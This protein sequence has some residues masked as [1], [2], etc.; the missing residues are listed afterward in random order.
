MKQFICRPHTYIL[1]F[2]LS[3]SLPSYIYAYLGTS[4]RVFIDTS[5]DTVQLRGFG[6]GG[7]LVQEGYMWNTS[8]FYGS[9]SVIEQQIKDLVGD[10]ATSSFYQNYYS[11]YV[12]EADIVQLS[13]WG[14]NSLRV[15]FHYKFFSPDTGVFIND[16]FDI[17]DPVLEWCSNNGIYLI[18]DMHCAPGGQNRNDFSDG[19]GEEAGLWVHEY[20]RDW[21]V[22]VWKY[23]ADYYSE[24]QWIGGYDLLNEP[25]LEGGF[26]SLNLREYYIEIIDSIRSVDQNHII[27]IEG[28]W[29]AND[30]A[31][32]TPP[33]DDNMSYSFHHYIGPS[34]QTA[35]VSQYTSMSSAYNVP[36]WVGEVGEN[37]NHWAHHKIKL[38][39]EN[40]IGWSWW[41]FKHNGSI[42]TLMGIEPPQDFTAIIKHWS[43]LGPKPS[44]EKAQSG[45]QQLVDA[46]KFENC[47]PNTGLLAAFN[48][49]DFSLAPRP[50]KEHHI[51]GMMAAVDF[52]I[53]MNGVAY[54]DEIFEDAN[55]FS[56][57]SKAW[58]SGW[59][60][61]ND[62][63]DI[64]K[65]TDNVGSEYA[66]GWAFNNEWALYT[67]Q[68]DSTGMYNISIRVASAEAGG[69]LQ[70]LYNN[71]TVGDVVYVPDTGGWRS[72]QNINVGEHYIAN[73][74]GVVRLNILDS[75]FNIKDINFTFLGKP[76]TE[77]ENYG[78][79]PNPFTYE[80]KIYLSIP[81]RT[82]GSL[83]IY[84]YK[85]QLVKQLINGDFAPGK[86]EVSWNGNDYK[87]KAAS[88]GVYIYQLKTDLLTRSGKMLLIK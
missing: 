14:F 65:T 38:F 16:G 87:Y 23:I 56:G 31:D 71:E 83:T 5:G 64:L 9:T 81:E 29:Y 79:Y 34:T 58:N 37:S 22:S 40:N 28:N 60:Y 86:M 77:D 67:V 48:D 63:V 57:D 68:T 33:F 84:N 17:I 2:L 80:T 85:G 19:N 82:T 42:S 50:F 30:F 70:L 11:S 52:D 46:Y 15:P 45:L 51:P 53:G 88:S 8:G 26:S 44:I 21:T 20:N 1:I 25:V 62:G 10:S 74:E 4:G 43:N 66:V 59:T 12:T 54:N 27:F 36:L 32:L 76:Q 78:N 61:R 3:F 69:K 39:E 18:L 75:E 24:A 13:E 55:K 47:V 41:N 73:G 7:W 35:W 6:L 49:P 72:W